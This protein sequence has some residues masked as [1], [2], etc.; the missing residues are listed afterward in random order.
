VER[1][2]SKAGY[3]VLHIPKNSIIQI[4]DII[5]GLEGNTDRGFSEID[6]NTVQKVGNIMVSAFLDA[7]AEL[8]GITMVTSTPRTMFDAPS[9]LFDLIIKESDT[10]IDNVVFF[11]NE[12][13]YDEHNL[14]CNLMMI[15]DPELLNDIIRM[16]LPLIKE[17]EK[18]SRVIQE[19]SINKDEYSKTVNLPSDQQ[20]STQVSTISLNEEQKNSLYELGN[21]VASHAATTLSQMLNSPIMIEVPEINIFEISSINRKLKQDMAAMAFCNIEGKSLKAGFIILHIPKK[22]VIQITDI[23]LGLEDNTGRG[24]SEIDESTTQE[25]GNLI[26]SAFLDGT[27]ELTGIIMTPS[28]TETMFDVPSSLFDKII[29]QSD[30]DFDNVLIFRNEMFCDE[31]E[32]TYNIMMVFYPAVLNDIIRILESQIEKAV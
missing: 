18:D 32:L 25:V 31:H 9:S 23:M 11:K 30:T 27:E 24:F 15:P 4:T 1:E 10:D 21:I 19:K 29:K 2:L 3:I 14:T 13:F 26:V 20:E 28:T 12:M 16:L 8:L 5:L 17:T 7:T 22:S 6:E